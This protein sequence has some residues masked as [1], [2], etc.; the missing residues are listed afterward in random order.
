MLG[1]CMAFGDRPCV[2]RH[3]IVCEFKPWIRMLTLVRILMVRN[4]LYT[5]A[6]VC[7]R[8]HVSADRAAPCSVHACSMRQHMVAAHFSSHKR[9]HPGGRWWAWHGQRAL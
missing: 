7:M 1:A 6:C 5:H 9:A 2:T 4:K 3:A 8:M